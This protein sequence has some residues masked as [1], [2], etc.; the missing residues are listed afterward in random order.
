LLLKRARLADIIRG[1]RA[2]LLTAIVQLQA[3][4]TVRALARHA[5]VAAQTALT[6]VNELA[7]AGVVST[8][9][10]GRAQMVALN[11]AHLLAEPLI[12]LSRTR[13]RLVERLGSE[14]SGWA[15][16]AGA[17][18]FGSAARG[19]GGRHSDIDVLL[20]AE[21]NT[22]SAQWANATA[23][24]VDQVPAWTGN[25]IQLVEH[26]IASFAELVSTRNQLVTAIREDGIALTPTTPLL[27]RP[28]A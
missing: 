27:L 20:V 3:P 18:L 13:L 6:A 16:L 19:T 21:E 25:Q 15:G 1:P 26:S 23:R 2:Q 22:D 5:G 24:L 4:V 14:L 12:A 10:A 8:Q 28:A 11:R 9:L 17:W 7:D